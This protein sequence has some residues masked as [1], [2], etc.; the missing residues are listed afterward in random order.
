MINESL[1]NA[2][3]SDDSPLQRDIHV[4]VFL[5]GC[6]A[7][8]EYG[9]CPLPT[10][11][12]FIAGVE[13]YLKALH[14]LAAKPSVVL[15]F[16]IYIRDDEPQT[17][18]MIVSVDALIHALDFAPPSLGVKS[19]WP[20]ERLSHAESLEKSF[21]AFADQIWHDY[22]VA[23]HDLVHPESFKCYYILE[24]KEDSPD[25]LLAGVIVSTEELCK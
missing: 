21:R 19:I 13:V 12:S 2:W 7:D 24:S 15:D 5:T 8:E 25:A 20:C 23:D 14:Y 10:R 9:P 22:Q 11:E 18:A 6:E 17:R 16:Y 4:E 1:L 3:L